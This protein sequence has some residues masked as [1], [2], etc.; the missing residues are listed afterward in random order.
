MSFGNPLIL[1]F[2]GI[3]FIVFKFSVINSPSEP[4]PLDKPDTKT[5]F[6]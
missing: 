3:S 1:I 4:S 6:L 5:P 2:L